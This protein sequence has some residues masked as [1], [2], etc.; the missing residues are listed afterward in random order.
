M[1]DVATTARRWLRVF[2]GVAFT[3]MGVW[4]F[5]SLISS[6]G[7]SCSTSEC[8]DRADTGWLVLMVVQVVWAILAVVAWLRPRFRYLG[9][10]I[11]VVL[12]P[13]TFL[14]VT[15]IFYPEGFSL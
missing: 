14:I 13:A 4:I 8:Q 7:V 1:T 9:L 10:A 11:A 15:G 3:W 12:P 6:M 2:A 5:L